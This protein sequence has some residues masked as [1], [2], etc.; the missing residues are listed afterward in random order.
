MRVAFGHPEEEWEL[1]DDSMPDVMLVNVDTGEQRLFCEAIV[2]IPSDANPIG[3]ILPS[4]EGGF[5]LETQDAPPRNLVNGASFL[6]DGLLYRFCCPDCVRGTVTT[7]AQSHSNSIRLEFR[8][9][10]DEEFVELSYIEKGEVYPLGA[11]SHNHLL[12]TLARARLRDSQ[13]ATPARSCGWVY[14]EDL[15][16]GCESPQ[17]VDNDVFRIRQHLGKYDPNLAIEIIERRTRTRQ[18]RLGIA[19]FEILP[20]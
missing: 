20:A 16:A 5:R 8:V 2:G 14:K 12:L 19:D 4:A 7:N 17:R 15:V 18:L 6:V 11:R 3:T 1:A 10:A 9:S 13:E